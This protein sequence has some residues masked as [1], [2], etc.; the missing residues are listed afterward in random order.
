MNRTRIKRL[1]YGIL[2]EQVDPQN[3]FFHS[4]FLSPYMEQIAAAGV[5]NTGSGCPGDGS[6][7]APRR[8]ATG[9]E[10]GAPA[11]AP[12]DHHELRGAVHD[13]QG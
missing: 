3:G 12:R 8:S 5:G 9:E 2:A 7:S 13:A 10:L 4:G 11:G 6:T 1:Y